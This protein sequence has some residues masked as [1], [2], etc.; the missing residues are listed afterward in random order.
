M[1]HINQFFVSSM[2]QN[3]DTGET[4]YPHPYHSSVAL[5]SETHADPRRTAP[6][7]WAI[8]ASVRVSLSGLAVTSEGIQRPPFRSSVRNN[9]QWSRTS[10][11]VSIWNSVSSDLWWGWRGV[12]YR[13][14]VEKR[15]DSIG[16]GSVPIE[17]DVNE[18]YSKPSPSVKSA[19]TSSLQTITNTEETRVGVISTL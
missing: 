6:L 9:G 2:N 1:N 19:E 7:C 3:G 18:T 17:L 4:P 10:S 14:V 11:G 16:L 8:S 15:Q 13:G 5:N 12:V